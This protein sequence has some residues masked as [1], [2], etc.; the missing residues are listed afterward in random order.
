MYIGVDCGTQG[1]KVLILD[2]EHACIMGEGY[3]AHSLI[4]DASGRREQKNQWWINAFIESYRIVLKSSGV[5]SQAIK[6][7]S[8]SGQQHGLVILDKNGDVIRPAKL[9]CDT[10]TEPQNAEIL[11][12]IGGESGSLEAL[13][14][15]I[16]TGY[17]V[18]KLLWLKQNEPESFKQIAHILLPHDYFNY[19]LTG[20]VGKRIWRCLRHG[21]F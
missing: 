1:T 7:I 14:L 21:L 16:A 12:K 18:S 11:E 17:T 9:W 20:G 5:N 6:G 4:S 13:G 15:V 2:D 19:W 3:F 8:V 10:E